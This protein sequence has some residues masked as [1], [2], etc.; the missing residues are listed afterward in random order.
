MAKARLIFDSSS[1]NAD[2][3]YAT[4]FLV[5]DPFVYLEASG[6]KYMVMSDL[7]IDRAK[8]ESRGCEVL[9][10]SVYFERRRGASPL[11]A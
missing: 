3:Y 5:G 1:K 6:K 8:K 11:P 9:K 2:L 7:E 10:S 4:G